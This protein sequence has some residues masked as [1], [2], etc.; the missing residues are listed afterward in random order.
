[1][2][3][4]PLFVHF[5]IA[6]LVV[7]GIMELIHTERLNHSGL[8]AAI[9]GFLVILGT[10]SAYITLGTGESASHLLLRGSPDFRPLV[11][12]HAG[13][14]GATTAIF[15]LLAAA[16]IIKFALD[17]KHANASVL[18]TGWLASM[19]RA[20]CVASRAIRETIFG[21]FL[22]L[23]GIICITITGGL[24]AAIVYGPDTDPIVHFVYGMFF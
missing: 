14:A 17:S 21:Q 6:F 20:L 23:A 10:L 19:W 8:Y 5:P 7:Y 22:A 3:I 1:M 4:H 24:G 13:F 18:S 11:E 16:Y 2:N 15:S 12:M 9:K